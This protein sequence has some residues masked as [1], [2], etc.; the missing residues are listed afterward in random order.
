MRPPAADPTLLCE[1]Q[2][3]TKAVIWGLRPTVVASLSFINTMLLFCT[4]SELFRT[5][6][7]LLM[8][9]LLV[10]RLFVAF[11]SFLT[12]LSFFWDLAVLVHTKME[13]VERQH[14]LLVQNRG[15]FAGRQRGLQMCRNCGPAG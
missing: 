12:C 3:E 9:L 4:L 15:G 2:A 5:I 1:E 13:R 8:S 10:L 11:Y 6:Y 14:H 7:G